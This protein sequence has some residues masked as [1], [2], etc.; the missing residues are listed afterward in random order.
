[1]LLIL[2]ALVLVEEVGFFR[3]DFEHW[4]WSHQKIPHL[5]LMLKENETSD[6]S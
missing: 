1:M 4:N 3:L 6:V 2:S 5:S